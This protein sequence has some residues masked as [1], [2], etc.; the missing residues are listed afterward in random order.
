M[1]APLNPRSLA[2]AVYLCGWL[3]VGL[4]SCSRSPTAAKARADN[5]IPVAVAK[6][7]AVPLDRT[8]SV[9]GTLFAKDQATVGAQVEG[10]CE[11]TLVDFGDRLT[12][13]QE[14]ALIDTTTYQALAQQ[15]AANLAKARAGAANAGQ[16]LKRAHDLA[17][18]KIASASDLDKAV[19]D[20]EQAEADVKAAEAAEAVAQLNLA[21]SRVKAPFDGAVAQRIVSKGDYA[22]AGSPLFEVVNDSVLKFIFQVPERYASFVQKE[23][24]VRFN[25]DNYPG[26]TFSG[27]VYLISP[28]VS[29]ASR[30]FNVGALVTNTNFR[31][32]ANT[33]ARGALVLERAVPTPM[34]PLE[35]VVSFAGVTKVF[36]V[37]GDTVHARAVKV[38]RIQDRRQEVLEGLKAGERV[39]VSGQSRL[40]EGLRVTIQSPQATSAPDDSASTAAAAANEKR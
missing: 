37:E 40:S 23:L 34:I 17:K 20:A 10:Q 28:A 9:I 21:H 35:G 3:A 30:A 22:K 14:I 39:V 6:V 1:K 33:F 5:A 19:A 8:V 15:A 26:E 27:G 24:R 31:L 12:T 36:V 4:T 16:N 25:V 18:E 29:T 32:K 2:R 7:E 38:G 11:K 13:G